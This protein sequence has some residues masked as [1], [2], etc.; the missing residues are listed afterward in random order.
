MTDSVC[1]T[2]PE[3]ETAVALRRRQAKIVATTKLLASIR[4]QKDELARREADVLRQ[5][6]SLESGT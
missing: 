2:G 5:L 6:E 1:T 3:H 4:N